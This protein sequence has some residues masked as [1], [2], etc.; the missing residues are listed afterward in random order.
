MQS[1]LTY[2]VLKKENKLKKKK[3]RKDLRMSTKPQEHYNSLTPRSSLCR[4]DEAWI[5]FP[6]FNLCFPPLI[7]LSLPYPIILFFYLFITSP[8]WPSNPL[9][10]CFFIN[11]H[12]SC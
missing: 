11:I 4:T 2:H 5:I 10:L 12:G 9:L 8:A 1:P 6:T 7:I 3:E